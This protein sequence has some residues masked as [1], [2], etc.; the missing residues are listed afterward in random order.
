[1]VAALQIWVRHPGPLGFWGAAEGRDA[2]GEGAALVSLEEAGGADGRT[3]PHQEAA[4]E[5]RTWVLVVEGET[6]SGVARE[7]K[8]A[9]VSG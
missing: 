2:M 3:P 9:S 1:M 5:Q 8:R 6:L 4:A 7:E